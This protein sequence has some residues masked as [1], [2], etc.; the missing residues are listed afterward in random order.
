MTSSRWTTA[1]FL[2]V[3]VVLVLIA[4]VPSPALDWLPFQVASRLASYGEWQAL[5]P[6]ADAY[7]LFDVSTRYREVAHEIIAEHPPGFFN[8][9]LLTAFVSPPSAALLSAPISRWQA[10]WGTLS[11]RLML[12]IP[13]ALTLLSL[14]TL[15]TDDG[16]R[17]RWSWISIAAAPFLSYVVWVGQTS[18]WLFVAAAM[19]TMAP[20]IRRDA[21]GGAALSVTALCKLTPVLVI[22]GLWVGGRRRIAAISAGMAGTF[23]LLTLPFAGTSWTKFIAITK[24]LGSVIITDW[25]N[26]SFD[27]A[28]MRAVAGATNLFSEPGLAVTTASWLIRIVVVLLAARTAFSA[29]GHQGRRAAA[30]W[31]GWLAATPLLWI[32]YLGA[33]IPFLGAAP[34]RRREFDPGLALV[35]AISALVPLRVAGLGPDSTGMVACG[36]W[37]ACAAWL[38]SNRCWKS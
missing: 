9:R 28:A 21:I 7:S 4:I 25:N 20:T 10:R 31:V 27:A 36:V 5:Y 30:V 11:L 14:G 1:R 17:A 24:R 29:D 13:I 2:S 19:T 33:L 16:V 18:G 12:A 32:H 37:L 6:T 26:A 3:A 35:V 38:L 23:F 8:E 34:A 22:A 15:T